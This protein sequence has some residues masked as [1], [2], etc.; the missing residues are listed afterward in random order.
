MSSDGHYQTA[1]VS[2][3]QI[4]VS[5][6]F[7]VN[8]TPE[9]SNRY[10]RNIG[11]D[12]TGKY[13]TALDHG[14]GYI[15]RSSNYG[16]TWNTTGTISDWHGVA[17]SADGSQQTVL[18][19]YGP[20]YVSTDYGVTWTV[21]NPGHHWEGVAMSA[22]GSRQTGVA[23]GSYIFI[24]SHETPVYG[25]VGLGTMTPEARLD[26]VG[27]HTSGVMGPELITGTDNRDFASSLG[28]WTGTGWS[29]GS[30]VATHVAGANPLTLASAHTG[31]HPIRG[32]SYQI[33]FTIN[34]TTPNPAQWSSPLVVSLGDSWDY[35]FG[36]QVGSETQTIVVS[37]SSGYDTAL[38]FRP[39][40]VWEGS[41]DNI[42][43]KEVT[44]SDATQIVRNSD[45]S[46]GLEIRS[47]GSDLANSFVGVGAGAMNTT[48]EGS[49]AFGYAALR[50]NTT[51][52]YNTATGFY[53]LARNTT[54]YE[55]SAYGDSSLDLNTTGSFNVVFG[56]Y[57]N[58]GTLASN[59][60][61][62]YN[63]AV[64]GDALGSV[65]TG[66]NNIGLGSLAGDNLT[67]GSNNI[68]I[69]HN[70]DFPSATGSNQ[71][72]IGNLIFATGVNGTGSTL[73]TG[74]VGIG[75]T[76]P[77]TTLTSIGASHSAWAGDSNYYG[78]GKQYYYNVYGDQY[79]NGSG[80]SYGNTN[81]TSTWGGGAAGGYFKGGNGDN[82]SGGGAGI[83]AIG[84]NANTNA[85]ATGGG[86]GIFAKGGL[87]GD[88][89]TRTYAGY[90]AGGDVAVMN[91]NVGI[92]T[93]SPLATL[94]IDTPA[95]VATGSEMISNGT[96]NTD[97]S[98]WSL[99][100]CG[101][102]GSGK[103][104]FNYTG[105]CTH[106]LIQQ[107]V[108]TV[109]GTTYMITFTTSDVT[110]DTMR[111]YLY[112]VS[113][114]LVWA[115][116]GPGLGNGTHTVVFTA[117]YTGTEQLVLEALNYYS[118]GTWAIDNVSMKA[119]NTV[120]PS[121]LVK[122][123]D[124]NVWLSLGG[125]SNNNT[126][127]GQNSFA[128]TM[129]GINNTA[130][131]EATLQRNTIGYGNSAF[132]V[133]SLQLNTTGY[134]NT[135]TGL[136]ALGANTVGYRNTAFGYA[137]LRSNT[138]GNYNTAT[139]NS[140]LSSNVSGSNSAAF[141]SGALYYATGSNNTALGYQSGY[142][143][144]T[145]ANNLFLGYNTG[146]G[147]TTGSNN[148]IL[149][150]NVAGLSSS[151]S[152]NIIIA[153][154]AGN[155][156]IN[157]NSSGYVGIGTTSPAYI[158]DVQH[159]TSKVNSKNGYLTNG[160]DYAEY[161][162][163]KDTNL[164]SGEA[165]CLDPTDENAIKRCTSNGDNNIMGIVST[166]PSLIGNGA[167]I[168]RENDSNYKII[169]M[170]GQVAG[171]VSNENGDIKVGDSLTAASISG[172]MRKANAGESTVG[173]ALENFSSKSGTI[174]IL[175]SRRNQ[176]LTVEKVEQTVTENIAALNIK[177]QVS[178]LVS[179]ASATLDLQLASQISTLAGLQTQIVDAK[180]IADK[181]QAQI[182]QLKLQNA[183]FDALNQLIAVLDPSQMIFK[184]TL[185]NLDLMNGKLQAAEITTGVLTIKVVDQTSPTIGQAMICPKMTEKDK[186]NKCTIIQVDA[187]NDGLDDAT[188]NPI[189]DGKGV[190]VKTGAV[191]EDSKI[192]VT[193]TGSTRNQVLY[194]GKV[195]AKNSFIVNIDDATNEEIKFNWWIVGAK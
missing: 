131:G 132:G 183:K 113:G 126:G 85:A 107:D 177:D 10:W 24:S 171:K 162:V 31:G 90:F 181:L 14:D 178:T 192:Y 169:G 101:T 137:A 143:N 13:Q 129:T 64:G 91:G 130:F 136:V 167:G 151:L 148:T 63:V 26:I 54:G 158:L 59:T 29:A 20:M 134:R 23:E 28:D 39:D 75:T 128:S 37:A 49:T 51:G 44:K 35:S 57:I 105:G 144:T 32:K 99:G 22:D 86:A 135:A 33:T 71:L 179:K 159:V 138:T 97:T 36:R 3:G 69:G 12:S 94:E 8:W 127:M 83:L 142:D 164:Q 7:G 194:V 123:Y 55:N 150:G 170:L 41:I 98:G 66:S 68:A 92:G 38:T 19:W 62:S 67:S 60:T 25:N 84:G 189:N 114:D 46:I 180:V 53:V 42:S 154:G 133:Q 188:G 76:T 187:N 157:V 80:Y 153:D 173:V 146:L 149:G 93:T 11:M 190:Q 147:I 106:S 112:H 100:N 45:N 117:T 125:V 48:G 34:T 139:G 186:S 176:S 122:G 118:G 1:V 172:L 166:N 56:T 168:S 161:F 4:Y 110:V 103:V 70:I 43:M 124:G 111:L 145:G 141:G 15:Y 184:D 18:D 119:T 74:Y 2:N 140:A 81:T 16:V 50:S 78:G 109:A 165:V 65:S 102:Y 58:N 72:N 27:T 96:F 88:G 193:P 174:Q 163:T 61:G 160:A 5:S 73:S 82:L 79:G 40:G 52:T 185:G 195:S 121:L 108:S 182:E 191:D 17:I 104:S 6:D 89:I 175:I 120:S 155:Q 156:R 115:Y 87:N 30:G 77:G 152:N 95:P 47:G 9:E 116:S 21:S